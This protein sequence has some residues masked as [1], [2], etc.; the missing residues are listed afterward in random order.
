M[1]EAGALEELLTTLLDAVV[2]NHDK[3]VVG[4]LGVLCDLACKNVVT[5]QGIRTSVLTLNVLAQCVVAPFICVATHMNH[6]TCNSLDAW[7]KMDN[8]LEWMLLLLEEDR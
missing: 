5:L 3:V 7:K 4:A 1:Q 2:N 6:A 8:F